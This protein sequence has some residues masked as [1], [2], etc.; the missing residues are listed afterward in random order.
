MGGETCCDALF[1]RLV[2]HNGGVE[3]R[4]AV[5]WLGDF[6][7]IAGGCLADDLA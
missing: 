4:N 1:V 2:V 5:V 6:A 7:F 3:W